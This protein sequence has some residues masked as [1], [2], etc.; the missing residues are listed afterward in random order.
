M[1]WY[2]PRGPGEYLRRL[3]APHV[4]LCALVLFCLVLGELRFDW[5]ERIT[6]AY[7]VT[8]NAGRPESGQIWEVGQQAHSAHQALEK[9]VT[10]RIA[11]QREARESATFIDLAE[12]LQPGQGA[13][14]SV[15]HF[16]RMYL[17]LPEAPAR[18][19]AGAL[20]ILEILSQRRC[21]RV[22]VRR[23]DAGDGLTV[24]LLDAANQVIEALDL[25]SHLVWL[26]REPEALHDGRLEQ[27]PDFQGRI[28]AADRFFHELGDLPEEV[29]AAVVTHPRRL[30]EIDGA[31]VRVGIS[32][33]VS[34]GYIRLGFEALVGG[35]PRVLMTRGRE[36][37]VWQV[38]SRLE[39]LAPGGAAARPGSGGPS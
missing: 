3:S 26:S 2:H 10:D 23:N 36:W 8:T 35:V 21:D 27:W 18:E 34:G 13:M 1:A 9:I 39:H 24:H 15:D 22:Y 11:N 30:L 6:G 37:A 38:H 16:R 25:P 32:S 29:R 20:R 5:A 33:E 4:V 28:Y 31:I 14:I 17:D 7:L 12:R 19:T